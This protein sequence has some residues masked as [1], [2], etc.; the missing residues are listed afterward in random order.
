M[1]ENG[2]GNGLD[3]AIEEIKADLNAIGLNSYNISAD[4]DPESFIFE[5]INT[6]NISE[7]SLFDQKAVDY[8]DLRLHLSSSNSTTNRSIYGSALGKWFDIC[9]TYEWS[10]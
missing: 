10:L 3:K 4:L 9:F 6:D 8:T 1:T 2:D 5:I 7:Y